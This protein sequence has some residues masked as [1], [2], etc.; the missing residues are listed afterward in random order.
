[1]T[2]WNRPMGWGD[3]RTTAYV[4]LIAT[5]ILLTIW[6]YRGSASNGFPSLF[7]LVAES[8]GGYDLVAYFWQFGSF[9]LLCFAVPYLL[10]RGRPPRPSAELGLALPRSPR[11]IA[12][13][14]LA[15]PLLVAPAAWI[16][17]QMPDV[18]AAYPMLQAL[19]TRPD[20]VLPYEAAY[21]L[22]YYVAWEFF[23]H[24]Y[25]LFTLKSEYGAVTAVLIQTLASCLV[26]I[27]KP[28]AEILGSI[29]VGILFG[30]IA[31]RTRSIWPTFLLHASLGVM[32]DLFVLRG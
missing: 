19:H 9:F 12:L 20:L 30:V 7:V 32:T 14:L 4:A 24:G 6:R 10:L 25:L 26:H 8:Q 1:M 23:F 18:R 17:A 22:L 5:P 28:E 11:A 21:V 31:L 27:G 2:A 3:R 13:T 16:G 15:V 29:P